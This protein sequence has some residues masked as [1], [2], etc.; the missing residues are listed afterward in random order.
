MCGIA[1]FIDRTGPPDEFAARLKA[2]TFALRHRGPDGE[3][4]W[5][6]GPVALGHRRLAIVDL[7]PSGAQPMESASGRYVITYNGEIYNHGELRKL[8]SARNI[9]WRGTS[10]TEA[11]LAAI[12][13]WGLEVALQHCVGMFAF[14]L[15]DRKERRLTLARDRFGEKPLYFGWQRGVFLFGSE[16]K[17]LR[18][19]PAFEADISS[20]A[21]ADLLRWG[22]ISAPWSIFEGIEK[23]RAGEVAELDLSGR[24][25]IAVRRQRYW[26][27]AD[28]V[29][30]E[31][32][33]PFS[34]SIDEAA[35]ELGAV[36]D[37]AIRL[38]RQADVPVGAFLSGGVD[39]SLVV[40]MMQR[41]SSRPVRTFNIGFTEAGFDESLHARAVAQ[42]LGT[43][44]YELMVGPADA[45]AVI[46]SLATMFDEPFGDASQIPTYLVARLARGRVTVSVSGDGGDEL[47][48]GYSKY[49]VGS[50]LFTMPCRRALGWIARSDLSRHAASAARASSLLHGRLTQARIQ[51]AGHLL[52]A[53]G[54]EIAESLGDQSSGL[55]LTG[56][57]SGRSLWQT[58]PPAWLRTQPYGV[59]ATL[60]DLYSYLPEDVLVK[61][62]RASMAVSLESRAPLLDHRVARF[63][64]SLPWRFRGGRGGNEKA[65]LRRLLH[66][67][68][69]PALVDRPK[70]GFSLPVGQWLRRK[71]LLDWGESLIINTDTLS[72]GRIDATKLRLAWQEHLTGAVDRAGLLWSTLM[73]LDWKRGA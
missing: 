22:Y 67:Y 47:F 15:W 16:L 48:G 68:V 39:S 62:D 41:G 66:R 33:R 23:L 61:V 40:A 12:D 52:G 51:R 49:R 27:A 59:G 21:L 20:E 31:V 53:T 10:D 37:E 24:G 43:D 56:H 17:A 42:H 69:P 46:P 71:E 63:A 30:K 29:E 8:L 25:T 32:A 54:P 44:H 73:F 3:G 58:A 36:L 65:V 1:G 14:A 13:E 45:I 35:D 6:E 7:S 55:C 57:H 19:H 5:V 60:L 28:E 64:F 70:M 11:L 4:S 18:A 50:R 38:Q 72:D 34:K 2:M 9:E 26:N